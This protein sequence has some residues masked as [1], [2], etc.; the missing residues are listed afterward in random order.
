M[1]RL[2]SKFFL[3]STALAVSLVLSQAAGATPIT[4]SFDTGGGGNTVLGQ[5]PR[6]QP[7]AG[8]I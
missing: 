5:T 2:V 4:Y 8:R 6:I 3:A 1:T 7:S